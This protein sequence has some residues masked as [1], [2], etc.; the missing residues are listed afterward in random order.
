MGPRPDYVMTV[1]TW[2]SRD[3]DDH[4]VWAGGVRE[5]GL[6]TEVPIF[7]DRILRPAADGHGG[8]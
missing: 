8:W 6:P 2:E 4:G 1:L 3:H 5:S 7:L